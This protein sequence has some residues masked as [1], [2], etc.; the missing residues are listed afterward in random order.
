MLLNSP[1]VSTGPEVLTSRRSGEICHIFLARGFCTPVQGTS[2]N[3]AS[4]M[5]IPT[6]PWAS[7]VAPYLRREATEL[8]C[9]APG[10]FYLSDRA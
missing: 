8:S 9:E 1:L 4:L 3:F 6:S 5:K 2:A 10:L 7:S